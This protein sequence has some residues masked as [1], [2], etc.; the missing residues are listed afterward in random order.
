L[1]FPLL[2]T[3]KGLGLFREIDEAPK[4]V[5]LGD[6]LVFSATLLSR[7][8]REE[9]RLDGYCTITS[10]PSGSDEDRELCVITATGLPA[11]DAPEA[12]L[13]M[14][15][16]GRVEAED[17]DFGIT[18]GTGAFKKAH[19]FATFDFTTPDR[20]IITFHVIL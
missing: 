13:E 6:Q 4:G 17:I 8:E 7:N 16:V 19:G 9:G 18:G 11:G 14:Q 20:A 3:W 1:G 10:N 15:G 2:T 5:S 12:E